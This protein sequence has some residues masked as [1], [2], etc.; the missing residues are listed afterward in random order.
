MAENP[1]TQGGAAYAQSRPTYPTELTGVLADLCHKR[2]HAVDIGCGTGQLTCAL[3]DAFDRA[4]GLDPS[5]S[6]IESATPAANVTYAVAPAED[7]ALPDACADLIT[8]A[9]AAH[10]FDLP[11]FY[12][13]ARRIAAQ[14]CVLA[15]ITYGV[16][17]LTGP[18][19]D[20]FDRFYWQDIHS[21]WPPAR[22]HVEDG[23]ASLAFPFDP[24]ST[25]P[26]AINRDW[27]FAE[28][29]AYI[30]T[31]SAFRKATEAGEAQVIEAALTELSITYTEPHRVTW[32]IH[33]RAARI[34]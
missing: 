2:S 11:A 33:I 14:G 7:T 22:A 24:L 17:E 18:A 5:A 6:Q 31:W 3:T 13:E 20:R 4:T 15:L 1:F 26:L 30:R 32:P 25:P 27:S 10:W 23:Y 28:M 34:A 12:D 16:P 21:F 9:Q 8:V 19:A 29:A